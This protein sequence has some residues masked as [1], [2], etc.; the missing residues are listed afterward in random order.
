MSKS[1]QAGADSGRREFLKTLGVAGSAAAVAAVSG[2]A[3]AEVK[4]DAVDAA[5]SAR[6]YNKT[7]HVRA[8]Y[9]TCRN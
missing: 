6:G 1:E 5:P 9:A 2:A 7:E 8:Y 4:P 3:S